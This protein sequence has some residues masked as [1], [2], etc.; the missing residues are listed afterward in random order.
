MPFALCQAVTIG[1]R[2]SYN[3]NSAGE[4]VV[5][6]IPLGFR[7]EVTIG[8]GNRKETLIVIPGIP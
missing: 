4:E 2:D 6:L 5:T 7:Q 1:E 8:S 3:L